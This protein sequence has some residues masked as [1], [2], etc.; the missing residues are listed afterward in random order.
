MVGILP[1]DQAVET[2]LRVAELVH[3]VSALALPA[4]NDGLV[5]DS[6]FQVI[7]YLPVFLKIFRITNRGAI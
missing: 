3:H 5:A 1:L 7:F 6:T 4:I 2:E